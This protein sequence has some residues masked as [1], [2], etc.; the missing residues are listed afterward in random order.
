[1]QIKRNTDLSDETSAPQ[2]EDKARMLFG[3]RHV[4]NKNL[5]FYL[6]KSIVINTFYLFVNICRLQ[7]I[8][9]LERELAECFA[10]TNDEGFELYVCY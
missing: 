6:L 7:K 5:L 10:L 1:M 9:V 2:E 4:S 8:K 3:A